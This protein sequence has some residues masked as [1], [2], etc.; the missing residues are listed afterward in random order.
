MTQNNSTWIKERY[1]TR[2][3]EGKET[4]QEIKTFLKGWTL[5]DGKSSSKSSSKDGEVASESSATKQDF[6]NSSY[7]INGKTATELT[8]LSLKGKSGLTAAEIDAWINSKAGSKK[9]TKCKKPS[10]LLNTGAIWIEAEANAGYRADMMVAHAAEESGWGTSKICCDKKNFFGYGAVDSDPYN[11]AWSN[12]DFAKG[13][14]NITNQIGKF[15]IYRSKNKPG[16][17]DQD[18]LMLMHKPPKSNAGHSYCPHSTW[19]TNIANI[20]KNAPQP[21]TVKKEEK[22]TKTSSEAEV[23]G[24]TASG[25]VYVIDPGPSKQEYEEVMSA[26]HLKEAPIGKF[27]SQRFL[28]PKCER[29]TYTDHRKKTLPFKLKQ[30]YGPLPSD[31]FIHTGNLYENY[32]SEEARELFDLLRRK[33]GYSRLIVTRGFEPDTTSLSS[34]SIGIAMDI[35]ASTAEEA[36]RIADTAW[37]IGIRAIAIGPKFVHVD[38]GPESTWGY[39]NLAV[40]RGP[41][42]VKE[43]GL[44]HGY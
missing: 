30:G 33:L 3:K 4:Y 28:A 43:R 17:A 10:H 32:Y 16:A 12:N 40:Y 6:G 9:C 41:G 25:E 20:W 2:L 29:S 22:K 35:Y 7:T 23:L 31:Q 34:H 5:K 19:P 18:T 38:A 14:I 24:Q 8:T 26:S 15:Y 13:I 44:S 21:G 36:I 11:G 37:E 1:I 42:T 39:D 27:R